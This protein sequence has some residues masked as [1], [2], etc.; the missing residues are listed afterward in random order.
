MLNPDHAKTPAATPS[1][2]IQCIQQAINSHDL[3]ALTRC[4]APDYESEF[5]A[6]LERSFRGTEQMRANWTGLFTGVPDIHA[7]LLRSAESDD[8][9]WS[10]WEWSGTQR[11]GGKFW[12]RGVTVQRVVSGRVVW[13]RLYIEP[14]Q[15]AAGGARIPEALLN[16]PA[17]AEQPPRTS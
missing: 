3:D 12:Q 4:F 8:V 13:A 2:C 5:P 15:K 1:E 14:V 10:E 17:T 6:H 11:N 16:H 7:Q 9:A